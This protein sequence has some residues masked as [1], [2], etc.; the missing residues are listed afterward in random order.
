MEYSWPGNIRE[1][2]N[3]IQRAAILSESSVLNIEDSHFC[4]LETPASLETG[5]TLRDVEKK[6]NS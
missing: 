3:V 1:L 4:S 6:K 5:S 2:Q